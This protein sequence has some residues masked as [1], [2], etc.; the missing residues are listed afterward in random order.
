MTRRRVI[1]TIQIVTLAAAIAAAVSLSSTDDWLPLTLVAALLIL[2]VGSDVLTMPARALHVSSSFSAFVLAMALLGPA[3][4]VAIAVSVAAFDAVRRRSA[5]ANFLTNVW[6]HALFA[7]AGGFALDLAR[8]AF[9]GSLLFP[10]AVL[11]AFLATNLLNFVLA[12]GWLSLTEGLSLWTGM[13]QLWL[14]VLPAEF[15]TALLTAGVVYFYMR[16]GVIAVA[17]L[18]VVGLLF[19]YLMRTA[20]M[21]HERG[22][23]LEERNR[24]LASLQV[25]LIST[26]LQ[27][28]ALRDKMT[29]RHS[30]AVARYSRE[31]AGALGLSSREQELI[32]TAAL[33]HDIGKFIFPDSIL[34]ADSRLT[35]EE[36][37]I[38][39]EHPVT[40]AELVARIEGYGPVAELVRH[41]HERID[42]GGYP[43]GVIG[44]AI[45]LGSRIIAVADVYDVI[46]ARD[47]YRKPVSVA[48]AFAELRRV[49]GKQLDA[50]LV[51][52]FIDIV[53]RE[54]IA[55]KHSSEA[56]FEAELAFERRVHDYARPRAVA[57]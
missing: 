35:D 5:F 1:P 49:A 38:V 4:A 53:E 17:L 43:D 40:G 32:H 48:E 24:E 11:T 15:A 13:R 36:F 19:Q 33:F 25:G 34:L 16:A 55:Y 45:P 29:A 7:L 21:A 20:L 2:A 30:A 46:T 44:D 47:S 54:G 51:E 28:L 31:M 50:H 41:H 8:P 3:P 18:A 26:M 56:D 23:E 9:E 14:P 22:L 57:V 39:R 12:Y 37:A 52:I 42:G 6:A 27:T 10:A